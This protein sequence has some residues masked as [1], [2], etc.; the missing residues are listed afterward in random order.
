MCFGLESNDEGE[1]CVRACCG[2]CRKNFPSSLSAVQGRSAVS[3]ATEYPRMNAKHIPFA[4]SAVH[5]PRVDN[6]L[7][8]YGCLRRPFEYCFG[9]SAFLH[10]W[11]HSC[12]LLKLFSGISTGQKDHVQTHA[13]IWASYIST[14]YGASGQGAGMTDGGYRTDRISP[15]FRNAP[16]SRS[17]YASQSRTW[18]RFARAWPSAGRAKPWLR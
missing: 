4:A 6:R 17:L 2:R 11:N 5:K 9:Y 10:L 15:A 7:H 1:P 18:D 13:N 14:S 12:S 16:W 3:I 8:P